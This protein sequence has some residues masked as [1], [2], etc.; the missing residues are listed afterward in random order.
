MWGRL[1][2]IQPEVGTIIGTNC[3]REPMVVV[4]VE[5]DGC[6]V[7]TATVADVQH[8]TAPRSVMEFHMAP[9]RSS[10]FGLVRKFNLQ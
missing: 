7:R 10:V 6:T 1:T 2:G 5:P 3:Y 8:I 4:S 9:R